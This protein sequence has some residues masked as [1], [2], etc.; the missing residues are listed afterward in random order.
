[1]QLCLRRLQKI[2]KQQ[3]NLYWK[4]LGAYLPVE[5]IELVYRINWPRGWWLLVGPTPIDTQVNNPPLEEF[6][7]EMYEFW[8][9]AILQRGNWLGVERSHRWEMRFIRKFI[10]KEV[11]FS[12]KEDQLNKAFLAYT[13]GDTP[14][15][16]ADVIFLS[17]SRLDLIN[18]EELLGYYRWNFDCYVNYYTLFII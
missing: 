18:L 4:I 15:E 7:D 3:F 17:Y 8:T 6:Q 14:I 13:E 16:F 9:E 1:M 5:L 11:V 10:E 12:F 2:D